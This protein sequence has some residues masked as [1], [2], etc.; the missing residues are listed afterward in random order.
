M[1][2]QR[3]F[4]A[5]RSF[6][7][8]GLFVGFWVWLAFLVERFDPRIPFT[9]PAWVPPVGWLLAVLGI[10]LDAW[11]LI[12]FIREGRGTPAPFDPPK[13]FVATGP[14][15]HVRNPMYL[16]AMAT[17]L[18][19]ALVARSPAMLFLTVV[20]FL[21]AHLLTVLYEERTLE[22]RFGES[23]RAYK[24]RVKRWRPTLE[25]CH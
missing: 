22:R 13:E 8:G 7:W 4:A 24:G 25:R 12:H 3:I 20:F 10:G 19:F 23:Y 18:G 17:L 16:G 11:C 14:F 1:D 9:L 6:L 5:F 15:R 21:Y 2:A